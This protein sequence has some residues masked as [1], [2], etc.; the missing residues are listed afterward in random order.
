M[1]TLITFTQGE[2]MEA[3]RIRPL[4][5]AEPISR[6]Q[7]AAWCGVGER[8]IRNYEH[9]VTRVLPTVIAMYAAKTG[10]PESEFDPGP[11]T[12]PDLPIPDSRW[13]R[14]SR[15]ASGLRHTGPGNVR[16]RRGGPAG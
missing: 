12:P 5:Q 4:T 7:M 1:S 13:N 2:R 10:Y 3:A 8:T 9:G 16:P 15:R 6:E 11:V 14:A